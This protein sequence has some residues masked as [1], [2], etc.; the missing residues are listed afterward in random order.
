MAVLGHGISSVF[1]LRYRLGNCGGSTTHHGLIR[2]RQN[3]Q[4]ASRKVFTNQLWLRLQ[5]FKLQQRSPYCTK[6]TLGWW[7]G[8]HASSSRVQHP[9]S[10]R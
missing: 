10:R 9:K 8:L 4:D 7:T 3:L 2:P 5:R 1:T 6:I